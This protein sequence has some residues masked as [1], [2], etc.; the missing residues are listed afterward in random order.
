MATGL[1]HI[2]APSD[3]SEATRVEWLPLS[4]IPK[5]AADGQITDGPS[6]TALSY[7]LGVWHNRAPRPP[8]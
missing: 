4:D 2:G 6:L 5:L 7:Y 1:Q 8:S 3:P